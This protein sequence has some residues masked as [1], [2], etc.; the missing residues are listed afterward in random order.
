MPADYRH[1]VNHHR[2]PDVWVFDCTAG[3]AHRRGRLAHSSHQGGDEDELEKQLAEAVVSYLAEHRHAMDTLEGIADW[4][5]P[6]QQARVEV[7]RLQRV[8]ERLV[9]EGILERIPGAGS[10]SF[11]L[12][13]SP[14]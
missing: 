7:Q 8:L 12:K 2:G 9:E 3:S 13:T 14:R 10:V 6:R 5:I 4:W 11:R 1:S